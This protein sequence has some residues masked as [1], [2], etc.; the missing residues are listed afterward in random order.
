MQAH[1]RWKLLA[2]GGVALVAF[3][4]VGY[5]WAQSSAHGSAS[6]ANA[7]PSWAGDLFPGFAARGLG[8]AGHG[9]GAAGGGF[10]AS[11]SAQLGRFVSFTADAAA[12]ALSNLGV[13]NATANDTVP[14]LASAQMTLAGAGTAST[15]RGTYA[16]T[17]G[18]GDVLA[19]R[20]APDAPVD[21]R[22]ANGTT[23]TLTLPS[24]ATVVLHPAVA[25]WSP[26]GAT[27]TYADGRKA[28]L[29]LSPNATV[30]QDGPTLTVTLGP[31]GAM[32]LALAGGHGG[33]CAGRGFGFG[34][35]GPAGARG[36]GFGA[37][38]GF[39]GRHGGG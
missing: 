35:G 10:N 5:A 4:A 27:V 39:A 24:G 6:N 34:F 1:L 36:R 37:P 3:A 2:A 28:D 17:D 25:D 18:S 12:G 9:W 23:V 15:G 14:R 33:P 31:H 30:A 32:R 13:R 8:G 26:A 21:A 20:D 38:R 16:I 7:P 19:V 11:A 22:S 29:V